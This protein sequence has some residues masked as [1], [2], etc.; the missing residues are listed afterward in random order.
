MR[1]S[2]RAFLIINVLFC[3]QLAL[4]FLIK[5]KV[6]CASKATFVAHKSGIFN[7]GLC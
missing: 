1:L 6:D 5:E 3:A 7:N 2:L 4:P